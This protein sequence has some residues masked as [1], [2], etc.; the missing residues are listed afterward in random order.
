MFRPDHVLA[1][2]TFAPLLGSVL[3]VLLAMMGWALRLERRTL[4]TLLDDKMRREQQFLQLSAA[5]RYQ[6]LLQEHP[7]W[8]HRIPLHHLASWLGVTDVALSR[9]RRRLT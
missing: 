8:L 2:A 6:S 7:D 3:I 5:E 4:A 1:W 9:I